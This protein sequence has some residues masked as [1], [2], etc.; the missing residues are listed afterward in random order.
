MKRFRLLLVLTL[1]VSTTIAGGALA[2]GGSST[3]PPPTISAGVPVSRDS[4]EPNDQAMLVRIGATGAITRLG[5]SNGTAFYEI[6]AAGGG[7]C[8]AVGPEAGGIS[9][10]CLGG[11]GRLEQP[12]IDMSVIAMNPADGTFRFRTIQG[13]AA[14]GV[15]SVGV[16]AADGAVHTTPVVGNVYRMSD[17]AVPAGP[18]IALLAL[19]STGSTIFTKPLAGG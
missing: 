10:G 18:I 17:D 9:G 4:L 19:D 5:A 2:L 16:V 14:D 7:A 3:P 6:A 12:L 15:R 13:I 8:F 1:G 11:S